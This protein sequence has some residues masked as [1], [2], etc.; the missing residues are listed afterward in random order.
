S[1]NEV[2]H[3]QHVQTTMDEVKELQSSF[4]NRLF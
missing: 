3:D 2:L 1:Q 4:Y